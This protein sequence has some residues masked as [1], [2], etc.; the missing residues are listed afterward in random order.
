MA[1]EQL[2]SSP[3]EQSNSP[4]RVILSSWWW[5]KVVSRA[6]IRGMGFIF[7]VIHARLVKYSDVYML[8]NCFWVTG[9]YNLVSE[10]VGPSGQ[11]VE[12]C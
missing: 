2:H 11:V 4:W 10:Q 3:R 7:I 9:C 8:F 6:L 1:S 12:S 5:L